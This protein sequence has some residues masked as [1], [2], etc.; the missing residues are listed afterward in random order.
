MSIKWDRKP[1]TKEQFIDAFS[2][3][4]RWSHLADSLGVQRSKGYID[5]LR[6]AADSL[7]LDHSHYTARKYTK[8][9]LQE[10]VINSTS[11][12]GVLRYMGIKQ[13]GGTQAHIAKLL[14]EFSIDTSH[15]LGQASNKGREF[16]RKSAREV[17]TLGD[18]SSKRVQR[19]R[20]KRAMEEVG[21][22]YECA[23]CD[24]PPLWNDKPLTLEINHIS[25]LHWDNRRENLEFL[26]PNCH[27]QE[28]NSNRPYKFRGDGKAVK[29]PESHSAPS[30]MAEATP[31][32]RSDRKTGESP[33]AP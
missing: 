11:V 32:P 21:I 8:E 4:N 31:T 25:G 16:T 22:P 12:A 26:C 19:V 2:I 30:S 33:T 1:Y 10:A 13:A 15:F 24:C 18:E 9:I 28:E 7:G 29:A 3:N 6:R 5:S 20:L 14:R 23:R 27:S 17:L